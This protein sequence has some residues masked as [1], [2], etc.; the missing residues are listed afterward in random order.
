MV[1]MVGPRSSRS[2]CSIEGCERP[3]SSLGWCGMHRERARRHGDPLHLTWRWSD[4]EVLFW[5]HVDKTGTCWTWTGS[6]NNMGYGIWGSNR[7]KK[8]WGWSERLAHRTAYR[9]TVGPIEKGLVIDHL[10]RVRH[11]VRPNHL[12]QVTFAENMRRAFRLITHCPQGHEYTEEN[13]RLKDNCR[14]CRT[15]ARERGKTKRISQ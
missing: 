2:G 7:A 3:H 8:L 13:T 9:L 5:S 11:C 6:L 15:C 1:D 10:C 12:E 4:P 14:N